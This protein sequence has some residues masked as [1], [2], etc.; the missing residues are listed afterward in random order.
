VGELAG[1]LH[2][3]SAR[4]LSQQEQ[5]VPEM[6]LGD[7]TLR[8][9][10]SELRKQQRLYDTLVYAKEAAPEKLECFLERCYSVNMTAEQAAVMLTED[11]REDV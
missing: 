3:V 10:Y 5:Q 4:P 9:I 8:V 6:I 7:L 2:K 1:A 11:S